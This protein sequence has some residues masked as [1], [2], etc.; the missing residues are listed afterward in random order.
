MKLVEST[1]SLKWG[2][3]AM[4]DDPIYDSGS[5]KGKNLFGR[6]LEDIREEFLIEFNLL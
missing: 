5:Y 2:G 6:M 4:Q 1:V 3:G